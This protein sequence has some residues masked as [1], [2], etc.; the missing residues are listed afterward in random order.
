MR[1]FFIKLRET[2]KVILLCAKELKWLWHIFDINKSDRPVLYPEIVDFDPIRVKDF[3][4]IK[5][6]LPKTEKEILLEER[7]EH[8]SCDGRYWYHINGMLAHPTELEVNGAYLEKLF[9]C[10]INHITTPQADSYRI[11]IKSTAEGC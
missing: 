10:H 2:L 1:N 4:L 3:L 8:P 6:E 9:G 11:C 7:E 5:G